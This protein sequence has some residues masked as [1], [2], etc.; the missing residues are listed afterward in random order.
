MDPSGRGTSR[1]R[2]KPRPREVA[3]VRHFYTAAGRNSAGFIG[4]NGGL[5]ISGAAIFC[6][7]FRLKQTFLYVLKKQVRRTTHLCVC[8]CVFIIRAMIYGGANSRRG[9]LPEGTKDAA[10]PIRPNF[11]C[12]LMVGGDKKRMPR[13]VSVRLQL[14][15]TGLP[16]STTVF[17]PTGSRPLS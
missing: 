17:A 1:F 7:P 3:S 6:S 2:E 14:P 11:S 9:R 12:K 4:R 10:L 13:Q 15:E 5:L 8:V 16:G